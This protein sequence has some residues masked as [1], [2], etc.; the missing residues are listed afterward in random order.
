MGKKR[1]GT[2]GIRTDIETLQKVTRILDKEGMTVSEAVELYLRHII[3]HKR[4]P[5]FQ[6]K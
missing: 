1:D 2:V 4:I 6:I 3:K 5:K